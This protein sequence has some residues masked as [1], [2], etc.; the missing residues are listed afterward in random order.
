MKN[1]FEEIENIA[2]KGYSIEYVTI[3]QYDNGYKKEV[4][5][6]QIPLITYTLYII[7]M[8]DSETVYEESFDH[9]KDCLETGISYVKKILLK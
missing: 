3:N 4:D 8:E 2:K 1:L 5:G 7:R 9:I 6:R